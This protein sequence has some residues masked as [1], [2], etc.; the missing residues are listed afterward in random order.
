MLFDRNISRGWSGS[1]QCVCVRA[2]EVPKAPE[3]QRK[4]QGTDV[5]PHA[6]PAS[7]PGFPPSHRSTPSPPARRGRRSPVTAALA[8][9]SPGEPFS[10]ALSGHIRCHRRVL[11]RRGPRSAEPSPPRLVVLVMKR[12]RLIP[13]SQ[14]GKLGSHVARIEVTKQDWR[15]VG[16]KTRPV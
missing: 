2:S 1:S 16:L 10:V 14:A 9:A 5:S 3:A 8:S 15:S 13:V 6:G 11:A 7:T 12:L 4:T